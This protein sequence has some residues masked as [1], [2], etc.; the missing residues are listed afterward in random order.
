MPI[1]ALLASLLLALSGRPWGSWWLALLAA[2]LLWGCLTRVRPVAGGLLTSVVLV[3]VPATGYEGLRTYDPLAWCALAVIVPTAYGVAGGAAACLADRVWPA[4]PRSMRAWPWLLAW[5]WLDLSVTHG[6]SALRH[7]PVTPGYA[8]VGGPLT[9]L[10]AL[11][12]PVALGLALGTIGCAL[13][14]TVR[15][16]SRSPL[17]GDRAWIAAGVA[18]AAISAAQYLGASAFPLDRERTVVVSHAPN[19]TGGTPRWRDARGGTPV[20]D[21]LRDAGDVLDTWAERAAAAG[22]AD[23]HVWPEAALGAA[24][25]DDPTPLREHAVAL[26][27]AVLAGAYRRASDRTWRNAVVLADAHTARFVVDK[28][29]LV[30]RYEAWLAAGV[31]ALWPVHAAGWNVAVVVCW[32]VLDM[33]TLLERSRSGVDV[34]VVMVN[35]AWAADSITPWWH[36][37]AGH[38]AA[39]ATGRPVIVASHDGPSKVWG[40]DGRLVAH[41]AAGDAHLRAVLAVPIRAGTPYAALG[42]PGVAVLLGVASLAVLGAQLRSGRRSTRGTLAP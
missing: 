9:S 11:A 32:E 30:P 12:G 34:V 14:A 6:P 18:V 28:H 23:L 24:V 26:D 25:A 37:R 2:G 13:Q 10:A 38:L 35:D 41:A 17:P 16:V 19:A 29:R 39:W 5:A 7:L 20:D 22:A 8:L 1:V 4:A 21:A 36:A 27:A 15:A 42:G 31:G 40:H 33:P 3:P